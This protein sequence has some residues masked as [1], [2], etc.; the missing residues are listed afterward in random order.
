M[1]FWIICGDLT[2]IINTVQTRPYVK[3][4]CEKFLILAPRR[5][6]LNPNDVSTLS[7][8]KTSFHLIYLLQMK[9]L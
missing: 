6:S 9:N 3:G 4:L 2:R 5:D 7:E 1:K 8:W